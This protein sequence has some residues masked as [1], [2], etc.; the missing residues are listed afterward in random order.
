MSSSSLARNNRN[1]NFRTTGGS[2]GTETTV[3]TLEELTAAVE[4]SEKKVVI[5]SGAITGDTVLRV[6]SNTSIIGAAG[7]CTCR[8]NSPGAISVLTLSP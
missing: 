4:G 2:G 5:I 7:S 3:T 1:R 6:G 8:L